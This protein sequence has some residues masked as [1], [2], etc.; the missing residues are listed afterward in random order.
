MPSAIVARMEIAG[1]AATLAIVLAGCAD[2]ARDISSAR[3]GVTRFHQ[4][5]DAGKFDEIYNE[6]APEF[7]SATTHEDFL[8]FAGAVH[9]KLGAV[10]DATQTNFSVNWTTSGTRV[11]VDY[12]TK[13]DQGDA[14][15]HFTWKIDGD[16]AVLVGYNIN[17][18]ALIIK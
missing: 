11:V 3:A 7:R 10:R 12:T 14:V 6:A 9:R 1:V 5:L 16:K 15:E 8:A 18:K 4:Q 17:S 2:T 13:F